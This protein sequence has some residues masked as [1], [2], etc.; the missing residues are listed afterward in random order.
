MTITFLWQGINK[1]EKKQRDDKSTDVLA[2]TVIKDFNKSVGG[3]DHYNQLRQCN[4][5]DRR[6]KKWW[7]FIF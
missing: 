4:G 3:V 7:K 5:L 1:S 6:L 2:L